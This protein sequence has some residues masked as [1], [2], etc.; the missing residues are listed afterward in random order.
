MCP[1]VTMLLESRYEL[2][3]LQIS[4]WFLLLIWQIQRTWNSRVK[5]SDREM[6]WQVGSRQKLNIEKYFDANAEND[7]IKMQI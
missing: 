4:V 5:K 7:E 2:E 6:T 1:F 3:L